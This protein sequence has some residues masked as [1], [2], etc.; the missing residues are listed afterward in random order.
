MIAKSETVSSYSNKYGI[1]DVKSN[2]GLPLPPPKRGSLTRQINNFERLRSCSI[3]KPEIE[4]KSFIKSPISV[5]LNKSRISLP[6]PPKKNQ[7]E[8]I[9]NKENIPKL[10]LNKGCPSFSSTDSSH[11]ESSNLKNI[12]SI[13]NTTNSQK[14]HNKDFS[15]IRKNSLK[16][17]NIFEAVEEFFKTEDKYIS[18]GFRVGYEMFV[19]RLKEHVNFDRPVIS[20]KEIEQLFMDYETIYKLNLNLFNKL[21]EMRLIGL[22]TYMDGVGA[23][24]KKY[25][26]FM[27]MYSN[28]IATYKERIEFAISLKRTKPAFRE[29]CE[30]SEAVAG[31]PID[32]YL[33]L[34]TKRILHYLKHLAT[35]YDLI[36]EKEKQEDFAVQL[37]NACTDLRKIGETILMKNQDAHDRNLVVELDRKL[38]NGNNDIVSPNR[39]LIKY[40]SAERVAQPYFFSHL[41]ISLRK[42][43]S[44]SMLESCKIILFNDILLLG[45][46]SSIFHGGLQEHFRED[47]ENIS[48]SIITEKSSNFP[49]DYQLKIEYG[50]KEC[51]VKFPDQISLEK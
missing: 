1:S 10:N 50:N 46:K 51:V 28:T 29:F 32:Y 7:N 8:N 9:S 42:G 34:P 33:S 16:P 6:P 4:S 27:M 17:K 37:Y 38:F 44:R 26:P 43:F 2:S 5:S 22:K 12:L 30:I 35:I 15:Y 36:P 13:D 39:K 14:N 24:F 19:A 25:T 31:N 18:H 3:N 49:F 23:H 11:T 47:L 41:P 21:M 20:L 40:G 45:S 48:I